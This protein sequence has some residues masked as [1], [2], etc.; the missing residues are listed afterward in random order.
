MG[1]EAAGSLTRAQALLD[2]GRLVVIPTDTV[3]GVAARLDKPESIGRIFEVKRRPRSKPVAV[4]VADLETAM[5]IGEFTEEARR[6]A[7]EGWPGPLTLVVPS[8]TP[9]P[10]LGGHG[11]TVGVRVPDHRWALELLRACGPLA[12]TSANPSGSPTAAT[13]EDVAKDLGDHVALYVDGGRL[14]SPPSTVIS[15]IGGPEVLR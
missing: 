6:R 11:T 2:E 14:D 1:I 12:T 15:L 10:A 4:L 3:Y 9:L 7:E 8:V 13:I 5:R